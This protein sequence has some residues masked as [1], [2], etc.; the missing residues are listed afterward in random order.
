[1]RRVLEPEV[2]E[3]YEEALDY[4]RMLKSRYFWAVWPQVKADLSLIKSF[5]AGQKEM[6]VLDLGSGPG[7]V[8][9]SLAKRCGHA[10]IYA[11]DY[12]P[13]MLKLVSYNAE[14]EAL[15]D[16]IIPVK[17]DA[18]NLPFDN[19]SFDLTICSGMLH[20]IAEPAIVLR[21]IDRVMKGRSGMVLF[22]VV[23]PAW[24]FFLNLIADLHGITLTKLLKSEYRDSLCAALTIDEFKKMLASVGMDNARFFRQLSGYI[25]ITYE[26]GL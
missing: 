20:H 22:D 4:D 15:T 24:R 5:D 21:E 23:R 11:V 9:I 10:R 19:D 3:T 16:R 1:M 6:N 7:W 25:L 8:S 2:M 17:A 18:K 13:N 12:S 14:T 26:R